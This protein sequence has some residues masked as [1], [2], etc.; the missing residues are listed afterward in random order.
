MK[1]S[2]S[3]KSTCMLKININ[4]EIIVITHNYTKIIKIKQN[5]IMKIN[6]GYMGTDSYTFSAVKSIY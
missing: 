6:A 4:C 5:N 3:I 1:N 2:I